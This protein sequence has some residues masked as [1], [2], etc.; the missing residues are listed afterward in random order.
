MRIL[1]DEADLG[2]Y[3]DMQLDRRQELAV[4]NQRPGLGEDIKRGIIGKAKGM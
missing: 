1:A 3:I 2:I 4:L